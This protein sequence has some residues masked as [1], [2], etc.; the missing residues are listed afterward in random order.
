MNMFL[1]RLE[2]YMD[3]DE[4]SSMADRLEDAAHQDLKRFAGRIAVNR[5]QEDMGLSA[6]LEGGE[7][8]A[9][10]VVDVQCSRVA[11]VEDD[12]E[13]DPAARGGDD[14]ASEP[15]VS[16]V[17]LALMAMQWQGQ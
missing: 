3:S 5:V 14:A 17:S 7:L 6:G 1:S 8:V 15:S 10:G 9:D 11:A 2:C 4:S 16:N 12:G 13:E